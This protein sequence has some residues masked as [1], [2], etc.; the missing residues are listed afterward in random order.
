MHQ[1]TELLSIEAYNNRI[2]QV[3]AKLAT[4]LSSPID[5]NSLAQEA[6]FSPFHFSRIFLAVMGET[7]MKYVLRLRLEAS[8]N[9]LVKS[10]K[11][12]TQIAMECG[13]SSPSTYSR[14]FSRHYQCSPSQYRSNWGYAHP[15]PKNEADPRLRKEGFQISEATIQ[16]MPPIH[17]VYASTLKG[18]SKEKICETWNQ[19]QKWA[20]L[21]QIMRLTTRALAISLDDPFITSS[22]KC[23]YF[24]CLTI[25]DK[26]SLPPSKLIHT[27]TIPGGKFALFNVQCLADDL[28]YAYQHIFSDWLLKSGYQP[29]NNYL[30]EVYLSKPDDGFTIPMDV[31]ICVPIEPISE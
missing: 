5:L 2:K 28:K 24:A 10:T 15:L 11:N 3:V 14:A 8:A 9:M 18:Y 21:N 31:Q 23:R 6:G 29:A 17:V 27:L 20:L 12:L 7:P 19:I 1:D 26:I 30:Y 25:E 4:T 13:F 22:G 16:M